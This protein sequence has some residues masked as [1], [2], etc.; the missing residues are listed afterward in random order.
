[1][2]M[3]ISD[4]ILW[5]CLE[6]FIKIV[7]NPHAICSPKLAYIELK[8]VYTFFLYIPGRYVLRAK[9]FQNFF[10]TS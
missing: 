4:M 3:Y 5:M 7:L 6:I 8:G 10:S 1:M 2:V 9:L